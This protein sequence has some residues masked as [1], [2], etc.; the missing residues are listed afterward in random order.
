MMDS[1]NLQPPAPGL[2]I[3]VALG[4][5]FLGFHAHAGFLAAMDEAGVRPVAIS[6]SSAGAIAGGLYCAGLRGEEL[7]GFL[8]SR[9]FRDSFLD[10]GMSPRLLAVLL[11]VE[12][13]GILHCRKC[14]RVIRE[15]TDGARV[16]DLVDPVFRPAVADLTAAETLLLSE[17]DLAEAIV[18][19]ASIP[20][21]MRPAKIGGRLVHDGGVADEVPFDVWIDDPEIDEIIIHRVVRPRPRHG[22]SEGVQLF[23]YPFGDCH[24]MVC[25]QL[26][27][28]RLELAR[29]TGK[30]VTVVST[31]HKRPNIFLSRR[32]GEYFEAGK[33]TAFG[34]WGVG[35]LTK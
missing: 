5:S 31:A 29:L 15:V 13:S 25:E 11:G 28:C 30:R 27:A 34:L 26:L 21:L 3:A 19:S 9:R 1:E 33:R 18:A 10:F 17:G 32:L 24:E 2:R 14:V 35:G 6:G 12:N 16:E 7:R 20:G 8:A 4:S 23:R 22:G